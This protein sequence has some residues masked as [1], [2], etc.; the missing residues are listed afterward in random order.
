MLHRPEDLGERLLRDGKRLGQHRDLAQA[1]RHKVHVAL[2]IDDVLGHVAVGFLDAALG[3]LAGV[4]VIL[5]PGTAG[6][7]AAIRTGAAYRWHDEIPH[8]EALD[9]RAD[10]RDL[11]QCL[12]ADHQVI[13]PGRRRA[14]LKG[15]DLFVGAADP[16]IEQAQRHLVGQPELG[17]FLLDDLD[18]PR[19]RKD[20]DGLHVLSPGAH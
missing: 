10:G 18:L 19:S 17:S 8:P 15:A 2:M 4:A 13:I 9:G 20:R 5:V 1:G 12:V 14:V 6:Q 7:A 3:E 16:D 11:G